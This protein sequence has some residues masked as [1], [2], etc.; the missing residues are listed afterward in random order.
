MHNRV[1][2]LTK[3]RRVSSGKGSSTIAG[4]QLPDGGWRYGQASSGGQKSDLSATQFALLALRAA[5]QAGYP[6][7]VVAPKVWIRA[8]KWTKSVQVS[9]GGFAYWGGEGWKNSMT[10]CGIVSLVIC[11]EQMELSKQPVPSWMAP[12][13]KRGI[14][15]LG[16]NFN[17]SN[18]VSQSGHAGHNYY[19][20][21]GVERAG[22]I[23]GKREF[24]GK[25]WYVR[26]ARFLVGAQQQGGKWVDGSAYKPHDVLG[27]TFALLF[28]KRATPPTIT[29]TG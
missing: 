28:L 12:A 8:A 11:K 24:G 1:L 27:T 9:G 15:A 20:M 22:D 3:G 14:D 26:G 2:S 18:N 17:A 7:D 21:Y 23:V 13:I 5:S 25:D 4:H 16:A 6:M 10:A 19:Y 29:S